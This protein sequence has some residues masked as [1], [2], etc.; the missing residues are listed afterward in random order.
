MVR[1]LYILLNL[2]PHDIDWVKDRV[3]WYWE[4]KL[5]KHRKPTTEPPVAKPPT[6]TIIVSDADEKPA[7]PT[8]AT[9]ATVT[10]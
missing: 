1:H 2:V 6:P 5:F 7:E 9:T 4:N 10:T 3:R 8:P